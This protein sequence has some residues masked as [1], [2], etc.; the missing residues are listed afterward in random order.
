M[1]TGQE[2]KSLFAYPFQIANR[3]EGFIGAEFIQDHYTLPEESLE[4]MK[5]AADIIGFSLERKKSEKSLKRTEQLYEKIFEN[6]KTAFAL[7][8][9][10]ELD[11]AYF[12]FK[13][14]H[15]EPLVRI[16]TA[17]TNF[18]LKA[19]MP[20]EHLIRASVF[21]H[22]CGG[23]NEED[24]LPVI[25]RMFTKGVSS[26]LDYSVEGKDNEKEFDS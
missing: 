26:V 1:L 14:I 6:T 22:F 25:N 24:C 12:L 11:R 19:H 17:I 18:A 3:L 5:I 16:G 23:V 15:S 2:V 4:I 8:S 21:D 20:V 9:D 13:M 10:T 7:K